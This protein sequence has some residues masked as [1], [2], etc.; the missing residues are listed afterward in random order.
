MIDPLTTAVVI[1]GL[2]Y[3]GQPGAELITEFLGRVFLPTAD[4]LAPRGE[5]LS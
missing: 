1:A 4:A 3:V 2:K 5:T